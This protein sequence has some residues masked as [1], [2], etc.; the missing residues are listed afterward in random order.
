[1]LKEALEVFEQQL[2]KPNGER[3]VLDAHIPKDGTYR[4]IE[5]SEGEWKIKKTLDIVYDK[6]KGTLIGTADGDYR[7]IQELDYYSK[8]VEM[9]K[10]IDPKKVIHSNHYLSLAV[11]KESIVSGKLTDEILKGYYDILKNPILKYEKK[12]KAKKL[13]ESVEETFGLPDVALL[14]EIE[15]YVLTHNIWDGIPLEK[16]DYIKVFFIFSDVEK[17]RS[18]YKT[19]SER[20]LIPN[21]YNNNNFNTIDQ[22]EIVGLPNNNMGMNSKKPYLENKSRKVKVPYLLNQK[23]V[24]LQSQF[25]DYLMG[26]ISQRRV[27]I[28]VDNDYDDSSIQAYTD[29]EQPADLESGYYFRCKKEKNEVAI[30]EADVITN[31]STILDVPFRLS[32]YI[33]IPEAYVEK[34]KLIYD[35]PI[36]NL[37]EIKNLIDGVFFEGKLNRNYFTDDGDLNIYDGTLKRCLLESRNAL[38]SWFWRGEDSRIEVVF[39]KFSLE[40]IKNSLRKGNTFAAQRQFNLRWSLL[41]FLNS[42]WRIG[43]AMSE[44]RQQLRE[45]INMGKNQEWKFS[46]DEEFAYGVGQ[47]VSYLLSLSKANDKNHSFINPFLDAKNIKVIRRKLLHLYK[48]YNHLIEHREISRES[49]LLSQIIVYEPKKIYPEYIMA[50]FTAT[51]LIYEKKETQEGGKENE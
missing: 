3:L 33:K 37:W 38:A 13:Y 18:Y 14:S 31:Y 8:L 30:I 45:H 22:D 16:K 25:F 2:Q 42:D 44:I 49:Q 35:K 26:E 46:S 27:N 34:S 9:N 48:K 50:G 39:D 41:E 15:E 17:T 1:M 29:T 10:P 4:L 7:L 21:I 23:E 19:E 36:E 20:Y 5:M 28:Y 12:A 24:L 40:L 51:S 32:N 11:K 43:S 47:A 6:K